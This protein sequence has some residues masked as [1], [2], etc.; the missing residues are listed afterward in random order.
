VGDIMAELKAYQVQNHNLMNFEVVVGWGVG[1][2][3]ENCLNFGYEMDNYSCFD[4]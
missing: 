4:C 3:P 1:C 2:S